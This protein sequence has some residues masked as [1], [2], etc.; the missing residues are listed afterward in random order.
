MNVL[1]K[2]VFLG[3]LVILPVL[4]QAQAKKQVFIEAPGSFQ[5]SGNE[6]TVI[7]CFATKEVLSLIKTPQRFSF[8]AMNDVYGVPMELTLKGKQI[9]PKAILPAKNSNTYI[10]FTAPMD[11]LFFLQ[12]SASQ[13][14]WKWKARAKAPASPVVKK[15]GQEVKRLKCWFILKADNKLFTSDTV[16]ISIQQ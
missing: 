3:F 15:A 16:S 9:R 5:V 14:K 13:Y 6:G 2:C 1:N 10:I 7:K 8:Y 12:P 4:V 11:Q